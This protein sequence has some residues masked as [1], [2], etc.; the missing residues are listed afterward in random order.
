MKRRILSLALVLCMLILAVPVFA[1]PTVAAEL[2]TVSFA[3]QEQYKSGLNTDGTIILTST[4]EEARVPTTAELSGTGLS[5]EDILGWYHYNAEKDTFVNVLAYYKGFYALTEDTTFY[6]ITKT[7]YLQGFS[8]DGGEACAGANQPLWTATVQ[9]DENE[10]ITGYLNSEVKT[11]IG[12][13]VLGSYKDA[14][15]K[16]FGIVGDNKYALFTGWDP[17]QNTGAYY[18]TGGYLWATKIN[19]QYATTMVYHAVADGTV[20]ITIPGINRSDCLL[21]IAQNGSYIWPE[22]IKGGTASAAIDDENKNSWGEIKYT[23]NGNMNELYKEENIT[24]TFTVD[25]K[26]G[27][28]IHFLVARAATANA[29]SPYFYPTVTYTQIDDIPVCDMSFAFIEYR[30]TNVVDNIGDGSNLSTEP[31]AYRGNWDYI[32]YSSKNLGTPS[33]LTQRV[34][35]GSYKEEWFL[36]EGVTSQGAG[37]GFVNA[38]GTQEYGNWPVYGLGVLRGKVIG[39]R[40]TAPFAGEIEISLDRFV[41]QKVDNGRVT[42][43]YAIFVGGE[44]VWPVNDT[45]DWYELVYYGADIPAEKQTAENLGTLNQDIA[46]EL[47][48]TMPESVTVEKGDTVE[49]LIYGA[50]FASYDSASDTFDE[51]GYWSLYKARWNY[52]DGRI[53]YLSIDESVKYASKMEEN[54]PTNVPGS[55][56]KGS[57]YDITYPGPWDYVSYSNKAALLSGDVAPIVD[58]TFNGEGWLVADGVTTLPAGAKNGYVYWNSGTTHNG[59]TSYWSNG[60]MGF[61]GPGRIM[62]TRYTAEHS[63]FVNLSF[64]LLGNWQKDGTPAAVTNSYA[65]FVDGKQVWPAGTEEEPADWYTLAFGGTGD[66]AASYATNYASLVNPTLPKGIFVEEGQ[67]IEFLVMGGSEITGAWTSRGN[68]AEATVSYTEF[69]DLPKLSVIPSIGDTLGLQFAA[70]CGNAEADYGVL[71]D[72]EEISSLSLAPQDADRE[73]TVKAYLVVNEDLTLYT[74]EQTVSFNS[75]MQKYVD[76]ESTDEAT[77]AMAK[78]ALY[79]T[80]AYAAYFGEGAAPE[81]LD[82]AGSYSTTV[83]VTDYTGEDE[84]YFSA[85][86]LLVNEKINIKIVTHDLPAGA[87]L[88]IASDKDFASILNAGN[89]SLTATEDGTGYKYVMDGIS[90]MNWNTLYYFRV[91]NA[92]GDV[93]SDTIQYSVSTYCARKVDTADDGLYTLINAMMVLYEAIPNEA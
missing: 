24:D 50:G 45:G 63:G 75:I 91:V 31:I 39:T 43:Q 17:Y 53:K 41:N 83:G 1:L 35:I 47:N 64:D 81:I 65:I 92:D 72:G 5:E 77:K 25:V 90:M 93:I 3:V 88:Q 87:K 16:R 29:D 28:Q 55:G 84:V 30:P 56:D 54:K 27:D 34:T 82:Y 85:L 14:E 49:F 7:S 33:P 67:A 51:A 89:D 9:K 46:T 22:A 21:A 73:M 18:P 79:Y 6:P 86:S 13:W 66:N 61:I 68:F 32:S 59:G 19:T 70:T 76:D 42:L 23:G 12:G 26:A 8:N 38:N 69:I 58:Y 20:E 71:V 11:Y 40:Y 44:K 78:A 74:K 57:T 4:T 10:A 52:M 37:N 2:P 48:A 36:Q 62:G 60:G 15:F 80:A